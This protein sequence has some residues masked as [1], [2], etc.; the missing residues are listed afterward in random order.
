L[1]ICYQV[2]SQP[3]KKQPQVLRLPALR[4]SRKDDSAFEGMTV[5]AGGDDSNG[6]TEEAAEKLQ[7]STLLHPVCGFFRPFGL[8]CRGYRVSFCP[9]WPFFRPSGT[10]RP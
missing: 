5:F 1:W 7:L 8:F 6:T 3:N 4:F 9:W 2:F 10:L